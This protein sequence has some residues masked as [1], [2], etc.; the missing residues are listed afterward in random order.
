MFLSLSPS[1][2]LNSVNWVIVIYLSFDVKSKPRGKRCYLHCSQGNLE[3][4]GGKAHWPYQSFFC[5]YFEL[6]FINI[7]LP[8][9]WNFPFN[10]PWHTLLEI[11]LGSLNRKSILYV[12]LC[13]HNRKYK[14]S[15][16]NSRWSWATTIQAR[17]TGENT[18]RLG[19]CTRR[20]MKEVPR[21]PCSSQTFH[22]YSQECTSTPERLLTSAFVFHC[23]CPSYHKLGGIAQ[24]KV[25]ISQFCRS[26]IW[27]GSHWAETKA[28]ARLCSFPE[29]V[30]KN[31]FLCLFQIPEAACT[32]W[33]TGPSS[34]FKA[35]R[36]RPS[37]FPA[38]SSLVFSS[39]V[40]SS[41]VILK[42][43]VITLRQIFQDSHPI[44]NS[45]D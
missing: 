24:H 22:S 30:G 10:L 38:A 3:I 29:A 26:E 18:N 33:L 4:T 8:S 21:E 41:F 34:I 2:G 23:C 13:K 11:R 14:K 25:F 36:G 35:D 9:S 16:V 20:R 43:P 32:P 40:T 44:L 19:L 45:S 17:Q 37:P 12:N 15:S 5:K 6:E 28:L 42:D 31:P 39:T 1:R 27:H 7:T